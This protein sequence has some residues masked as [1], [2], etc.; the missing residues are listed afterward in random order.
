MKNLT[1]TRSSALELFE[2]LG[3]TTADKWNNKR[4]AV[5]LA[6]ADEMVDDDLKLKGKP[7]ATL[8]KVLD[9]IE[10]EVEIVVV[11]DEGEAKPTQHKEGTPAKGKAEAP[12]PKAKAKS[13]A[14]SPVE[15]PVDEE[16][17]EEQ[18]D[19]QAEALEA[20][21]NRFDAGELSK[22]EFAAERKAIMDKAKGIEP[23][24]KAPKAPKEPAEAK[25]PGVRETATRP[26]LAGKVIAKHGLENGIT[27]EMVA[28]LDNMYPKANEAES[29]GRLRN[30]WHVIRG[31]QDANAK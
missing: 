15:E 25:T 6:K 14:Q 11:D 7:K 9:A 28:E 21:K 26:Y 31:F 3:S 2:A 4:M 24:V 20:L 5:K 16:E 19:E 1:L 8:A 17:V 22:K 29:F 27:P 18:V 10:N 13:K 23:K 30:A 12:A